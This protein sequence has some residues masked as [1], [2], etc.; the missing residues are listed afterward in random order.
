MARLMPHSP[1]VSKATAN[2]RTFAV[3]VNPAARGG[4]VGKELPWLRRKVERVLGDVPFYETSRGG[5]GGRAAQ[6]AAADGAQTVVS[7]GGD[8]THSEVADGLLKLDAAS[9]P[10]LG[11]IHAGTG[12]DF[13]KNLLGGGEMKASLE[14]MVASEPEPVD[15]GFIEYVDDHGQTAG[16]HFLNL[17]SLGMGGLVDRYVNESG[18]R[19]GGTAA[20]AIATLRANMTYKPS[21]C[22]IV[23]DG[24]T[25]GEYP[26]QVVCICNGRYAGGGMHFAPQAR[27]ADGLLDVVVIEAEPLPRALRVGAKLYQGRHVEER[28]VHV[29]RG[30]EIRVEP[31]TENKAYVDLDGE[32]PGVAPATLRVLPGALKLHGLDPRWR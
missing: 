31:L 9:R 13:R 20:F 23:V 29:T 11:V 16:R 15:A 14:A 8:G 27:L 1:L 7:F 10:A 6:E 32:A 28:S 18:K 12:G 5:D 21:L 22:R 24:E 3:V 26:L 25:F 17:V 30:R 4:R 2:G 19:L